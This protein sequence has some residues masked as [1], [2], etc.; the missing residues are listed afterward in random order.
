[1]FKPC[2][3]RVSTDIAY[4]YFKSGYRALYEIITACDVDNSTSKLK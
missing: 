4:D 3:D 1:M 2:S